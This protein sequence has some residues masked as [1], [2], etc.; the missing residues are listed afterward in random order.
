MPQPSP[1]LE[2]LR[3]RLAAF[4]A[5][6]DWDRF[7]NP[8]NLAMAL[9]AEAAELLEHFLWLTPEEAAN[10]SPEALKEVGFEAADVLL[11]LLRL[12][13][14]LGIDLLRTADEKMQ[15]NA[16]RYP[17]DAVRGRATKYNKLPGGTR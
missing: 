8:K 13:D 14:K 7:H 10:L 17:A 12:T 1:D 3:A 5:E 11:Y 4:A 9:S 15:I 16:E 6:R 2:Q